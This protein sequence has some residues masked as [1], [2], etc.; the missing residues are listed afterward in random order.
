MPNDI[1]SLYKV[2]S[3][4]TIFIVVVVVIVETKFSIFQ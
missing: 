4:T 2:L 3:F 1:L